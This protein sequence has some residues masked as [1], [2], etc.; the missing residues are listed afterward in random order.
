MLFC[1]KQIFKKRYYRLTAVALATSVSLFGNTVEAETI[2]VAINEYCPLVCTIDQAKP[3]G[4]AVEVLE[5]A[6]PPPT[7]TLL[8]E[9]MPFMRGIHQVQE[10]TT[11]AM[12][13]SEEDPRF[14]LVYPK[15]FRIN[16]KACTYTLPNST[17]RYDP[18]DLSSLDEVK[19]GMVRYYDSSK[20]DKK[21]EELGD[22]VLYF[23]PGATSIELRMLQ[24][25]LSGRI[26]TSFIP[27]LASDYLIKKNNW[28]DRLRKSGCGN[29][30]YPETVVFSP[31]HPKAQFYAEQLD[32]TYLQ[33]VESGRYAELLKKYGIDQ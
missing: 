32:K 2:T 26:D 25:I 15:Q 21:L 17:W 1:L 24:M 22:Q 28:Q 12:A 11:T 30:L 29:T 33:L 4:L 23:A 18:N 9:E 16:S 31:N 14:N 7:Y 3:E 6:F 8:Y 10:G 19:I 13:T 20:I 27:D 5:T